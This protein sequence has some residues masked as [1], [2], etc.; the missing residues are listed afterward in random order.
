MSFEDKIL[1]LIRKI[2]EDK[3]LRRQI[4]SKYNIIKGKE[5]YLLYTITKAFEGFLDEIKTG[6][7]EKMNELVESVKN[8]VNEI[9]EKLSRVESSWTEIAISLGRLS[10]YG[11]II[12]DFS[13]KL[14]ILLQDKIN[15]K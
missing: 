14:D 11:A 1:E 13:G 9:S 5:H 4:D 15:K 3:D 2:D 8:I 6:I 7:L 12:G 10:E